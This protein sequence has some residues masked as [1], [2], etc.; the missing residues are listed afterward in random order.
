MSSRMKQRYLCHYKALV[1]AF[2]KDLNCLQL[3]GIENLPQPFLPL[4][5]DGYEES[6]LR[7]VVIGQD[8][9]KWGNMKC[10]IENELRCPGHEIRKAFEV[11]GNRSFA[12]WGDRTNSFWGFT[13][14]LFA[15]IHGRS[16]WTILK[17]DDSHETISVLDSIAWANANAVLLWP[18]LRKYVTRKVPK[19]TWKEARRVGTRFNRLEHILTTLEPH[20]VLVLC[21][22][23]PHEFF[24]GI[25]RGKT[26]RKGKLACC[27]V[28]TAGGEVVSVIRTYHP[29]ARIAGGPRSLLNEIHDVLG[30]F[31][32][33][34]DYP[35]FVVQDESGEDIMDTLSDSYRRNNPSNG[36]KYQFIEWVASQLR[37]HGAYMS[38]PALSQLLNRMGYRANR[39]VPFNGK[40]GTYK[41]VRGA[42]NRARGRG[43]EQAANM[44][45][46]TFC[47][48][49]LTHAYKTAKNH[50]VV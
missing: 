32:L 16:D 19:K 6:S 18:S 42:Y 28:N 8:T 47:R 17:R 11:M 25:Q 5:G 10:F 29:A 15:R 39:G 13:M 26:V 21:K 40:R 31:K 34:T 9:R 24:E 30:E 38:V 14:A 12:D 7:L 35:K 2:C 44:I 37:K 4:F 36:D 22:K 50:S 48:P 33:V 45:A 3:D 49:D 43:D 1:Q 46:K 27:K 41:L 23:L 20:V